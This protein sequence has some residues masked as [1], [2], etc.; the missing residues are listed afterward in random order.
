TLSPIS[1][2]A[3]RITR[4]LSATLIAARRFWAG[5]SLDVCAEKIGPYTTG[6][7]TPAPCC[8]GSLRH[9]RESALRV[10]FGRPHKL[11]FKPRFQSG[12]SVR[13][14]G[15]IDWQ[16]ALPQRFID[17]WLSQKRRD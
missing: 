10:A 16:G 17:G 2:E 11:L 7:I 15:F 6:L 9:S 14:D 5:L 13:S 12:V 3:I 1:A 4:M 8:E